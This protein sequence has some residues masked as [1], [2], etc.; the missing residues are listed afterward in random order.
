[1]S[2]Y[3]APETLH[4]TSRAVVET[5]R[6]Q[7]YVKQMVSHMGRKIPTEQIPGGHRLTFNRDNVFRGYADLLVD[8]AQDAA[9]RLLLLAYGTNAQSLTAVERALGNHLER[10]G[11]R[12]GLK[13]NFS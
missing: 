2:D 10:F 7:R 11:E 13:V 3:P 1:M 12:E 6:P 9:A 5:S 4:H 8:D